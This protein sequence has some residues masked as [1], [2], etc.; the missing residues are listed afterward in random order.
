MCLICTA[1][2]RQYTLNN[3]GPKNDPYGTAC[4]IDCG[5]ACAID[6]GTACGTDCGT[7]YGT[8]ALR[9]PSTHPAIRNPIIG[10]NTLGSCP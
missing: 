4:A 2:G 9:M 8:S 3:L 10:S 7:V 1:S 6:C 5:T